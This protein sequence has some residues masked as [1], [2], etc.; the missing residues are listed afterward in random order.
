VLVSTI[1]SGE[2][3]SKS[4]PSNQSEL[5]E[6]CPSSDARWDEFVSA[7]PDATVY[8]HSAWTQFL[9]DAYG[10]TPLYLGLMSADGHRLLGVLP[11]LFVDSLLTGKRLVSLPFT[12]YCNPLM[13]QSRLEDALSYALNRF[14]GVRYVELKLLNLPGEKTDHDRLSV[15]SPFVSQILRLPEDLEEL[16]RSFH[17]TSIRQMVR[18]ARRDGLVVRL[19]SSE[20]ELRRFYEL[21]VRLR[22]SQ[23]LPTPPY[24][25]YAG[26]RRALSPKGLFELPVVEFRGNIIAA[27][28]VLKWPS[29]WHL[30]YTASD[31]VYHKHGANQLLAWECIKRAHQ[32]G[33]RVFDFGRTSLWH[34]SLL[35]YKDRWQTRRYPI[36]YRYFPDNAKRPGW[37]DI[38]GSLLVRLNKRLPLAALEWEGRRIY[39]HRS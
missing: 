24:K 19:A 16:F 13:P 14:R 37:R 15:E 25:F 39:P 6:L 26:M 2:V 35:M 18:R 33:I 28:V 34:R 27:A 10:H 1:K 29:G 4:S 20:A 12:S 7:H 22:R 9:A 8:H 31:P 36:R 5:V 23:G 38:S 32:E 30:E 21:E 3:I 11:L 17:N